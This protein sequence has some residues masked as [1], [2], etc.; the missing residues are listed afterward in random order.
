MRRSKRDELNR[1][2]GAWWED[3]TPQERGPLVVG[4]VTLGLLTPPVMITTLVILG[5]LVARLRRR[6]RIGVYQRSVITGL[7][8]VHLA[9]W[10]ARWMLLRRLRR[11]TSTYV[12]Q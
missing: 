5:V 10:L 11:R 6:R 3:T 7:F 12:E 8:G 4:I 2:T 9:F 1:R